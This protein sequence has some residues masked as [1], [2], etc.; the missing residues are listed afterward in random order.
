ML[1]IGGISPK[2]ATSKLKFRLSS[3]PSKMTSQTPASGKGAARPAAK[4]ALGT[5]TRRRAPSKWDE[6]ARQIIRAEM[7]RRGVSYKV[8]VQRMG[9]L[10]EEVTERSLISRINR[11]TFTFGFALQVL[12]A[13]GVTKLTV[14]ELE[15][16]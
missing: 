3:Y 2:K 5:S 9:H 12:R 1:P 14:S 11:G 15:K 13:L 7:Q 10:G 4:A 8:L 6:E 16:S